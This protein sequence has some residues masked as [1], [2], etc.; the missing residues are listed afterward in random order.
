MRQGKHGKTAKLWTSY[1]DHIWLI[2]CLLHAVKV[3]SF[4]L[5]A[6][7]LLLMPDLFFSYWGMNYARYLT[8]GIFIAN[9]E[10]SHPGATELLKKGAFSVARSLIPGNRCAVDKTMEETFMRDAKSRGGSGAGMVGLTQN[11]E[12]YQRWVRTT[13]E[14]VKYVQRTFDMVDMA[15]ADDFG[16]QHRDLRPSS[17]TKSEDSV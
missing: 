1:M 7:T 2:L 17:I 14:R 3:N 8:F 10:N 15:H 5:Y 6:E 13:H 4:K 9:I 16:T 11:Y 12:A